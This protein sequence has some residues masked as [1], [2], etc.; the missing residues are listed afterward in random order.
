NFEWSVRYFGLKLLPR[1]KSA[2]KPKD[3]GKD[4]KEETS[5]NEKESEKKPEKFLT[6]V[7]WEKMQKFA[8]RLDMAGSAVS[9]LPPA[10]RCFG[11]ALT[12]DAIETDILI[13]DEDAADCA[14]KYG[15]MQILLQNLL[16]QSGIF[17]HV[18]RKN[19]RIRCDFI[20]DTC[21][22]NFRCKVKIN[23]GKTILAGIVF[24]WN[25]FKDSTQAKKT[26][27]SQKL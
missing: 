18:K 25:Y 9:A 7:I 22:Y 17:I 12:W 19:I 4:K 1:K 15:L 8:K 5:D 13:A 23:I 10:L 6:D 16:S 21:R 2:G 26:I 24:V 20:E 3:S 27:V 11:N 14:Q